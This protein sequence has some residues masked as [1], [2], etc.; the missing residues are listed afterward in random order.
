MS[1]PHSSI[2][3]SR[4]LVLGGV[5][6][7]KSRLAERLALES[8]LPVTYVATATNGDDPEM[9]ARIA[10]HQNHRP[11]DWALVEEH[12]RLADTLSRVCANDRCVLVECLTLWLANL[13]WHP[14]PE[15]LTIELAALDRQLPD[16]PGQLI[17]VGNE[18][19]LGIIPADPTAR[20]F[21]DLAGELHQRLAASCDRVL[22]TVAGLPLTVKDTRPLRSPTTGHSSK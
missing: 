6:S 16:L 7:G 12:L 10:A 8:G 11:A 14:D 2:A 20:R 4:T 5:R 13:L 18:V 21:V 9:V 3:V 19:G 1:T 17:M 15:R 22:F